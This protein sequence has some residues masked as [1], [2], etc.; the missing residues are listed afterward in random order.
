MKKVLYL[1]VFTFLI[2]NLNCNNSCYANTLSSIE[3]APSTTNDMVKQYIRTADTF[4]KNIELLARNAI[5]VN[6]FSKNYLD[7][8]IKGIDFLTNQ[9][10]TTRNS[11]QNDQQANKKNAELSDTLLALYSI[12][13]NYKYALSQLSVALQTDDPD[14]NYKSLSTFFYIMNYTDQQLAILRQDFL[15]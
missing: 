9:I 12:F 11:L 4:S 1:I 5:S 10:N 6:H 7:E 3:L 13:A 14:I 15:K 8:H 2:F